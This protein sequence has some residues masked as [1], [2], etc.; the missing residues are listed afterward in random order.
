MSVTQLVQAQ[1][2]VLG[3]LVQALCVLA[4]TPSVVVRMAIL[5]VLECAV[6]VGGLGR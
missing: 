1:A 2:Q 4:R 5:S 3:V 6:V